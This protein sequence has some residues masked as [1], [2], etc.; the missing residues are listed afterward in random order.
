MAEVVQRLG[1]LLGE[2]AAADLSSREL[3]MWKSL[4]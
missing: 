4:F 1:V 3:S 2:P